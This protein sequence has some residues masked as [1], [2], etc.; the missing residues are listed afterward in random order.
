MIFGEMTTVCSLA[1]FRKW[2]RSLFRA[3]YHVLSPISRVFAARCLHASLTPITNIS[4][5]LYR[6]RFFHPSLKMD[7]VFSHQ[8]SSLFWWQNPKSRWISWEG[9]WNGS[10]PQ[11]QPCRWMTL[12]KVRT[13]QMM[14]G[15]RVGRGNW[16]GACLESQFGR[17]NGFS[18]L[19]E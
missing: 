13:F 12:W 18:A 7:N 6:V 16:G 11:C 2:F 8:V 1:M 9:S 19:P 14:E 17:R 3:T 10:S 5:R 15:G 4:S